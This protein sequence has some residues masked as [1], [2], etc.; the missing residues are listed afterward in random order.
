EPDPLDLAEPFRAV[1]GQTDALAEPLEPEDQVV[2]SMPDASPTKWHL[3]HTSWFFETFV[4]APHVP[5]YR[6][7]RAEYAYLFNSYYNAVGER[8]P[9]ARRGLLSR[10]PLAEV[11]RYRRHVDERVLQWLDR[12]DEDAVRRVGPI[13]ILGLHHEQQ[14]QELILTDIKHA[15]GSNP[16]R[17]AYRPWE[18]DDPAAQAPPL[19]WIAFAE[20]VRPVGHDGEGFAFDNER[21]RHS[22]F[23]AAFRLAARPVTNGEYRAFLEDGGYDRPELWLSD[24]WDAART[25]GWAAPLYWERRADGWWTLTLGGMRRVD[26]AEP[27]CH[28]SFYEA[29]A[30]ARWAGARLPTEAEWEHATAAVPIAGNFLDG[31]RLHPAPAEGT[32]SAPVQLFGD[33]WEWTQSPYTP[34]P[35]YRPAAGALGEY[36]GKFMCNQ[37]VLRGGSCATPRAHIRPTYR[38]FFPP[39][40]RWQFTGIRLANDASR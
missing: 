21:P 32:P 9:R 36:N 2:Q 24:G 33:V 31:G 1:R 26:D 18:R 23:V 37:M 4:L 5:G 11:L 22:Q 8:L 30:F 25:Q 14:H 27:V 40:A 3:A 17:P 13:L 39:A 10:P 15:F 12:A 16:L 28:V 34:Y 6:P 19:R 7:F 20:G 38:N 35:G 29:D